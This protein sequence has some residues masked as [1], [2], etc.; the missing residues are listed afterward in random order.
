MSKRL[1]SRYIQTFNIVLTGSKSMVAKI[2][3]V[4][5]LMVC[6]LSGTGYCADD[7]AAKKRAQ[8]LYDKGQNALSAKKSREAAGFFR[9][10]VKE[11]PNFPMA[12]YMLGRIA[13]DNEQDPAAAVKYYRNALVIMDE[14]L[15]GR[16]ADL[17]RRMGDG[18]LAVAKQARENRE[19]D[20]ARSNLES[21]EDSYQKALAAYKKEPHPTY[22]VYL[23]LAD[24]SI[25]MKNFEAAA[26]FIDR[27]ESI[28]R[29]SLDTPAYRAV[30]F[31]R[32]GKITDARASLAQLEGLALSDSARISYDWARTEVEKAEEQRKI[33]FGAG[34]AVILL[35]GLI[36]IKAL[37]GKKKTAP[38]PESAVFMPP[39]PEA[40]SFSEQFSEALG[41]QQ[42]MISPEAE[43][44]PETLEEVVMAAVAKS[45]ET[46]EL[47]FGFAL[48]PTV[49]DTRLI[50]SS[51]LSQG[52]SSPSDLYLEFSRSNSGH[53]VSD[54]GGNPFLYAQEK[55]DIMFSR[56]FPDTADLLQPYNVLIGLPIVS[57]NRLISL[58]YL[59]MEESGKQF[60]YQK[61]KFEKIKDQ[62]K[63]VALLHAEMA[64]EIIARKESILDRDTGLYNETF[65]H[66]TLSDVVNQAR[67]NGNSASVIFVAID[68]MDNIRSSMGDV[69]A[70]KV[71]SQ[72]VDIIRKIA[73]SKKAFA[74]VVGEDRFAIVY[75]GVA[76]EGAYDLGESIMKGFSLVKVSYQ[77]E[78][79]TASVAVA[80]F[81]SSALYAEK[82][83][84]SVS[85]ALDE[86]IAQG[87]NTL[88]LAEKKLRV[89]ETTRLTMEQMAEAAMAKKAEEAARMEEEQMR[90]QDTTVLT[91]L[92]PYPGRTA[93]EPVPGAA[94]DGAGAAEASPGGAEPQPDMAKTTRLDAAA[95]VAARPKVSPFGRKIVPSSASSVAPAPAPVPVRGTLPSDV[96]ALTGLSSRAV[97]EQFLM[98]EM[99]HLKSNPRDSVLL[100]FGIDHFDS[101][102]TDPLF[103]SRIRMILRTSSEVWRRFAVGNALLARVEEN[104]FALLLSGASFASGRDLAEKLRSAT[105]ERFKNEDKITISIGISAYPSM[106]K[107]FK[108]I[109]MSG[110][111]A[112]MKAMAGGGNRIE[113]GRE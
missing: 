74:C 54:Q 48:L 32:Q 16:E 51:S 45:R 101:M 112:M 85:E 12:H 25:E 64:E 68:G 60:V 86:A 58:I 83:H 27:A 35:A 93:S 50:S 37:T 104:G 66:E 28:N 57:G 73:E 76:L 95:P 7:S 53:W 99:E 91:P 24:A 65:Y 82:L 98:R 20:S 18:Y 2:A 17:Y 79:A 38:Q 36:L 100:Y 5:L 92:T 81:P 67:L 78:P 41:P 111:N 49:D 34:I 52:A 14:Q 31:A 30:L 103:A 46:A 69:A 55:T 89:M 21:A 40:D 113:E 1:K 15:K 71:K 19:E 110:R 11:D 10:A 47:S 39:S 33:L 102:K 3:T 72:A 22:L 13:Q 80:G 56:A 42:P 4:L 70:A 105:E 109:V 63:T 107:Q 94:A 61:K 9:E 106:V 6:F 62:L 77:S 108:N 43:A 26:D 88:V 23:S 90:A 84:E 29:K 44:K 8:A 96:D 59:G 75:P 87:G 97:L